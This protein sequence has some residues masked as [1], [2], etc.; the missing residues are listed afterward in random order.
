MVKLRESTTEFV[1]WF[2]LAGILLFSGS[3]YLFALT[4]TRSLGT[5]TPFG[6]VAFIV[7]W[8]VLGWNLFGNS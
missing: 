6:G 1:C 3:L 8:G 4:G 5:V 2:L 7:A